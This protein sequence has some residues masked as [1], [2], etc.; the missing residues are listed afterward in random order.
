MNCFFVLVKYSIFW[1]STVCVGKSFT[2]TSG[3]I[4]GVICEH[5]LQFRKHER[6]QHEVKQRSNRR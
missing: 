6:K 5:S 1:F 3:T 4:L 2:T